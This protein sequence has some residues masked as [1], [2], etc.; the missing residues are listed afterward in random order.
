MKSKKIAI[1][2]SLHPSQS[3]SITPPPHCYHYAVTVCLTSTDDNLI[4]V[5]ELLSCGGG[6][7]LIIF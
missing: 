6:S 4:S 7:I 2:H 3:V 5:D 1:S